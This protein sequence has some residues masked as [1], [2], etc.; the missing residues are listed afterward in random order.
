M[1]KLKERWLATRIELHWAYIMKYRKQGY[2]LL[3]RGERLNSAKMLKLTRKIDH[4]G[5]IAFRLQDLYESLY[6]RLDQNDNASFA[7]SQSGVCAGTN[8]R[9]A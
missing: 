9:E 4:H 7:L 8:K 3:E 1:N 2:K 6:V 5:I